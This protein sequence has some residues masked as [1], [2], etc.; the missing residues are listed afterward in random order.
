V[1]GAS[2]PPRGERFR[3][4][5]FG[6]PWEGLDESVDLLLAIVVTWIAVGTLGLLL[7][8]ALGR[9]ARRGDEELT[10][11]LPEQEAYLPPSRSRL[12]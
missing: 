10:G 3:I 11:P 8:T 4:H 1:Q 6:A 5:R 12:H 7:A 9:A 2:R